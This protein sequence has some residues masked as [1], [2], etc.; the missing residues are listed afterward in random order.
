MR[1]F[2]RGLVRIQG[3]IF[4]LVIIFIFIGFVKVGSG[5]LAK[6]VVRLMNLQLIQLII[7][8]FKLLQNFAASF[9]P[10]HHRFQA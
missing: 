2:L 9:R 7:H 6:W 8:C 10:I 5:Y 1:V 3:A 4:V